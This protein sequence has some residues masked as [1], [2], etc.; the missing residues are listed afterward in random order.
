MQKSLKQRE[1]EE[2]KQQPS[3]ADLERFWKAAKLQ[4][5]AKAQGTERGKSCKGC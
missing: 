3:L 5:A 2:V 1:Q 4:A